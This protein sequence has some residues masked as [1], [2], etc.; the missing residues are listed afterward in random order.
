MI[1][2]S[3]LEC[4]D[5]TGQ[6]I[7]VSLLLLSHTAD[8]QVLNVVSMQQTQEFFEVGGQFDHRD[9]PASGV[10]Q[11]SSNADPWSSSNTRAAWRRRPH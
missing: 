3:L 6:F 7:A 2:D 5:T 10:V 11:E 4:S 1:A 9:K 8:Q